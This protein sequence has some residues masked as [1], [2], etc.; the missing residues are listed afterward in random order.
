MI[1]HDIY[2]SIYVHTM[3][4]HIHL[5]YERTWPDM[6]PIGISGLCSIRGRFLI[7]IQRREK[8]GTPVRE[9]VQ[10]VNLYTNM[11]DTPMLKLWFLYIRLMLI[12]QLGIDT[13]ICWFLLWL[14]R[15][16]YLYTNMVYK[17]TNITVG[18]PPCI[19]NVNW[20]MY[21]YLYIQV[22]THV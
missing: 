10:L 14:I 12:H 20:Q 22:H 16:I 11:V 9:R 13:Q 5:C 4:L 19:R 3:V 2:T 21:L 15:L 7:W 17:P 6:I 8:G 1:W 18:V